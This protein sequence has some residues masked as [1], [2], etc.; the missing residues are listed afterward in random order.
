M[1]CF[2][3]KEEE[4]IQIQQTNI[5]EMSITTAMTT[6]G[7]K[8]RSTQSEK[9]LYRIQTILIDLMR[10]QSQ[11]KKVPSQLLI[12]HKI[13]IIINSNVGGIFQ[14]EG[15]LSQTMYN[16]A[17][18]TRFEVSKYCCDYKRARYVKKQLEKYC[19]YYEILCLSQTS[20]VSVDLFRMINSY[21]IKH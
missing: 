9:K 4:V 16:V 15:I 6:T 21:I 12:L 5:Q 13:F 17:L 19:E 7:Y 8:T 14:E 11:T 1:N 18:K 20:K 3:I 2:S 10:K